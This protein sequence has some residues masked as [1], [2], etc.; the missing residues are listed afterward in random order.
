MEAIQ[1]LRCRS[2]FYTAA[3][4]WL[5]PAASRCARCDAELPVAL[6][7]AGRRIDARAGVAGEA[8][9]PRHTKFSPGPRR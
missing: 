5:T 9:S 1:C 4:A 2:R 3:P 8:W 7:G 6:R